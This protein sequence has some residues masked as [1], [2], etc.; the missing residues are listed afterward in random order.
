MTGVVV[1]ASLLCTCE[2]LRL[3]GVMKGVSPGP[4][5][6]APPLLKISQSDDFS[7]ENVLEINIELSNCLWLCVWE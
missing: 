2:H 4:V 5:P 7:A 6:W 1:A 3:S